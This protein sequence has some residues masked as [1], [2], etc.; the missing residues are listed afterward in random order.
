M[1]TVKIE[2]PKKNGGYLIIN[3]EDLD[4]KKHKL[5]DPD[6]K[7]VSPAPSSPKRTEVV[8]PY[9]DTDTRKVKIKKV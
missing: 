8:K 6:K 7:P 9:A 4:L 3:M 5:Y 1:E 2:N